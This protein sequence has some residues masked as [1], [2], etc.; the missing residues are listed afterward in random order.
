M[1]PEPGWGVEWENMTRDEGLTISLEQALEEVGDLVRVI[2][3]GG[4]FDLRRLGNHS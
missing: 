4:T 2:D 1:T 3:A